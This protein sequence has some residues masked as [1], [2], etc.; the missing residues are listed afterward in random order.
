MEKIIVLEPSYLPFSE[1]TVDGKR[2]HQFQADIM[3]VMDG[4]EDCL[5][6]EAP[7]GAGKTFSFFLPTLRDRGAKLADSKVLIIAPTNA[8]V[9]EIYD[10]IPDSVRG[11]IWTAMEL[12]NP[13]RRNTDVTRSIE[14]SDIIVSNP[15]IISLL[16]SGF[17]VR[18]NGVRSR[19][20]SQVFRKTSV[21]VVDEYHSYSEEELSKILAFIVLGKGTG[22]SHLK[23]VFTSATPNSKLEEMLDGLNITHRKISVKGSQPKQAPGDRLL[24]GKVTIHFTD[25]DILKSVDSAVPSAGKALFLA[26]HVVT[27]ERIIERLYDLHQY[28]IR[29][30]TGF[31]NRNP[32]RKKPTGDEPYTVATSAAE[33][34]LNMGVDIAH[35]EPGRFMENFRQRY[36]RLAR[37]KD[38][39]IYVHMDRISVDRIPEGIGNE[40]DLLLALEGILHKKDVYKTKTL[41]VMSAYL[42]LVYRSTKS[43]ELKRQIYSIKEKGH[44]FSDMEYFDSLA[45]RFVGGARK[46]G[47]MDKKDIDSFKSWVDS[48]IKSFGFFRGQTTE[49]HVKLPGRDQKETTCDVVWMKKNTLYE[50]VEGSPGHFNITGYLDNL[51]RVKLKF[52]SLEYRG[53]VEIE[54]TALKTPE[55]LRGVWQEEFDD[56]LNGIPSTL[57]RD[58]DIS[59]AINGLK[60]VFPK[61][62]K[63]MFDDLLGPI[64]V[65][66]IENDLFL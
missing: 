19:Q 22:N 31:E 28:G 55:R 56:Y 65:G 60:D 8:L 21:I 52:T 38:G 62:L 63:P 50:Q 5:I 10:S 54:E 17:Y 53:T 57:C 14:G 32:N 39:I 40:D 7:T 13:G 26:N 25:E 4:P 41:G 29:E 59:S 45:E 30:I 48:Y 12:G 3:N 6:V 35:I 43:P 23:Y 33:L 46:L 16:V 37:G 42:Y 49:V 1:K 11:S 64:E 66:E 2:L 47:V 58:P 18:G 51:A 15:D 9:R 27:A 44:V 36:G 20:W 61:I 24:R 34:G